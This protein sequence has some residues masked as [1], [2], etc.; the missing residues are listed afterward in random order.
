MADSVA[1]GATE[2]EANEVFDAIRCYSLVQGDEVD[3]YQ[4]SAYFG[5]LAE[6]MATKFVIRD[7]GEYWGQ[8][9]EL[10]TAEIEKNI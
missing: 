1:H 10:D 6:M 2:E 8:I 3:I 4:F 5:L 9:E 7:E